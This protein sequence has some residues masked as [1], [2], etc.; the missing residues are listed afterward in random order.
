MVGITISQIILYSFGPFFC[1]PWKPIFNTFGGANYTTGYKHFWLQHQ[2]PFNLL[3]HLIC[4]IYQVV[5]NFTLLLLV[6]QYLFGPEP[7]WLSKATALIWVLYLGSAKACPAIA[8]ICSAI[9]IALVYQLVPYLDFKQVE[10]FVIGSFFLI[11]IVQAIIRGPYL[12]G[13]APLILLLLL[14]KSFLSTFLKNYFGTYQSQT[15]LIGII[16]IVMISLLATR[17]D[18]VKTLIAGATM[19]GHILSILTAEKLFYYHS[20]AFTAMLFQG[21]S[22]ELSKETA[23]LIKLMDESNHSAKVAY[24]WAHVTYF[25]NLLFH[26][27]I[28]CYKINTNKLN[29]G[30]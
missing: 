13:D 6:D 1:Y 17:L 9:S 30:K 2:D 14:L 7:R 4:L 10:Y 24:E 23:T 29:K 15:Q 18:A 25:P 11:W 3:W 20:I 16:Y 28:D 5:G 8:R 27:L 19:I 21:L 22:H 12:G 26:A